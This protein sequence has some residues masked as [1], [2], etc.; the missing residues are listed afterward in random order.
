MVSLIDLITDI[1]KYNSDFDENLLKKAYIVAKGAHGN[2]KRHSG[3]LYFSHPLAVAEILIELKLDLDSIIA[4]LLHDVVED[5]EITLKEIEDQFGPDIARL[6]DGVTKLGKIGAIPTSEKEAENF[7]KLTMAMSQDVRVLLIKLADRLHN[8]RTLFHVPSKEKRLIKARECLDIYAPLAARIGLDNIKNELQDI[9]FSVIDPE[10][11]NHINDCLNDLREKN[12]NLTK[13]IIEH[14]ERIFKEEGVNCKIYGREKKPYSIWLNMK[15]KNIGFHNLHDIIAF[16][17]ITDS[18]IECYKA[19]GVINTSF[20]MIPGT[21]KDYI[22]TPKDNGYQAIHLVTLGPFNKKIEIQICD[23]N[24]HDISENGVAAHWFYKEKYSKNAKGTSKTAKDLEQYKW[25]R[26]LISLF[27]SSDNASEALKHYD[28]SMHKN[29]VFCFTPDGDIF[30]LPFGSCVVDFAYE[31]HSDVG[32]KCSGAKVNGVIVPLRRK[33]E[34]GDQI[35]I[36]TSSKAKPSSNWL[37]FVVTSKAKVSIKNFIKNEKYDEYA[38]LGKA[39][40]KRHFKSQNLE[41]EDSLIEKI[42]P[43]FRKKTADDLYFRVAEGVISKNDVLKAIYPKANSKVSKNSFIDVDNRVSYDLVN[44]NIPISGLVEGMSIK[45][46][47]CCLPIPGDD[48]CGVLNTGVGI[49]I[50]NRNCHNIKGSILLKNKLLEVGWKDGADEG[51]Y[52]FFTRILVLVENAPGI[53]AEVS[54]VLM[55]KEA[56]VKNISILNRNENYFELLIDL[57]IANAQH[58]ETILSS[59]LISRKVLEAKR[60]NLD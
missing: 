56:N 43:K 33:I 40:L 35:E 1:K 41:F 46:A 26:E 52:K 17:V 42:L 37:Q 55:K 45:Y 4:G 20:N 22:S 23:H 36:M 48:I 25:I 29:E 60:I 32:N 49:T 5:T 28:L 19:L 13:K 10:S 38:V 15:K 2:Q 39:I 8:M 59:L 53:L 54:N 12:K 50:H 18:M 30:N 21:F 14:L 57:E 58:V 34:N 31:V 7:R 3:E 9:A 11:R 27:E 44:H 6:V 51:E 16:R 24:M 47:K